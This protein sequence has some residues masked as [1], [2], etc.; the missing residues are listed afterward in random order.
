MEAAAHMRTAAAM[1]MIAVVA[2]MLHTTVAT[3]MTA[4]TTGMWMHAEAQP[5]KR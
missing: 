4:M 5:G 3:L 1:A 2:V